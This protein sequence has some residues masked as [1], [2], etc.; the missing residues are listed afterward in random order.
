MLIT[1]MMMMTVVE[2]MI[3]MI[4]IRHTSLNVNYVIFKIT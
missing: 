1:E 3:I 4:S 2:I